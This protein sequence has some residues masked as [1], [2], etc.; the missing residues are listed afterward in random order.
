MGKQLNVDTL[1]KYTKETN[2]WCIVGFWIGISSVFLSFIGI[3][4]LIGLII[5]IIG[6]VTFKKDKNK[7]LRRGISGFV[8]NLIYLLV[9]AYMNGNIG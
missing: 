6:L 9:N 8:L 7:G 4:P 1:S 2:K 5:S 3:I